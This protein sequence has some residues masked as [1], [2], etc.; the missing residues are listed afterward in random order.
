MFKEGYKININNLQKVT[1]PKLYKGGYY[2]KETT[3]SS[4]N[5]NNMEFYSEYT[6]S[7]FLEMLQS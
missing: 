3:I 6:K 4:E 7:E 2:E 1:N 5:N